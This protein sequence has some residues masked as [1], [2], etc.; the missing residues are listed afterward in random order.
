MT[1]LSPDYQRIMHVLAEGERSDEGPAI[2][3]QVAR[4]D[5]E[6]VPAKIEG[7]RPKA[8]RLAARRWLVENNPG[9]FSVAASRADGS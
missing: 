9:S 4:L 8:K 6:P 5:L 3:R 2:C 7:V 1:V